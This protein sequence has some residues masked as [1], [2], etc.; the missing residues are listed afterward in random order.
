MP[1]SF[2]CYLPDQDSPPVCDLPAA[3]SGHV[4]FGSFNYFPKVSPETLILWAEI[5][6][7]IPGSRLVMKAKSF[8]DRATSNS[9]LDFFER[10]G[11][12]AGR[13]ELLTQVSL[14]REHLDLYNRVDIGLD[15]FPYNGTTTTCEA[16]WMG[17]PVVTLAGNTHASRVGASLVSNI[18]LGGL[19]ATT[20][21]EYKKIAVHL[22][23]DM[24]MLK[25]FREGLRKMI[26][27]SSLSDADRFTVNLENC[28]RII[29]E[30]WCISA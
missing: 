1:E 3:K 5:L 16:L 17:V 4:T 14:F 25:S 27:D 12:A 21:E 10:Q 26:V 6:K 19:V 22:A 23:A 11:V 13:I 7:T 8:S 29:W 2:L 9:V 20:H 15:T 30:K 24:H 28:Y 18:G